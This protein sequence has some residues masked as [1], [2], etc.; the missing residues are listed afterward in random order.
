MF[1]IDRVKGEGV[2]YFVH[3]VHDVRVG[4]HVGSVE[5]DK[6][7]L[8][9]VVSQIS[10]D[11]GSLL[12]FVDGRCVYLNVVA[13]SVHVNL[14]T[15]IVYYLSRGYNLTVTDAEMEQSQEIIDVLGGQEVRHLKGKVEPSRDTDLRVTSWHTAIL[16]Y[17]LLH[18]HMNLISVGIEIEHN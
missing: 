6:V 10:K 11:K 12:G 14:L 16:W 8:S 18:L 15:M 17:V 4:H 1:S 7:V 5:A 9:D 13:R 3:F 2:E